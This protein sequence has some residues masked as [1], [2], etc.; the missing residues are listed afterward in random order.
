MRTEVLMTGLNILAAWV[1]AL[2]LSTLP[3][4]Q[5]PG[6]ADWIPVTQIAAGEKVRVELIGGAAT[7]GRLVAADNDSVTVAGG[8]GTRRVTRPDVRR[9]AVARSHRKRHVWIGM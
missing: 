6:A 9:V 7:E 5:A 3:P 1:G 8:T 2:T 4:L